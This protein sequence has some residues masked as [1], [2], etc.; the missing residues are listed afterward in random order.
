MCVNKYSNCIAKA[1]IKCALLI[2]ICSCCDE[3]S[4]VTKQK[5]EKAF[6][7][8]DNESDISSA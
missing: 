7:L 4:I 3:N 8:A 2:E 6:V 5:F 1:T